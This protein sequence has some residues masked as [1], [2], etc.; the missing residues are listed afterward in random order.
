MR[1]VPAGIAVLIIANCALADGLPLEGG[2]Y[3]GPVVE[4]K[5]TEKQKKV[6]DHYRVCQLERSK[7][8]NVY[9]PYVFTLSPSQAAALARKSATRPS[10]STFT[11][12]SAVSTTQVHTG[13]LRSAT[14]QIASRSQS[15][16]S[17]PTRT[18]MQHIASK[19]GCST[20]HASQTSGRNDA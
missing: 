8:M 11:K 4:F 12:Q 14:R 5:L 13:I 6:I 3:P 16:F 20:T 19:A 9:T 10:G 2:R 7:A 17:F 1:L 15:A 18:Q